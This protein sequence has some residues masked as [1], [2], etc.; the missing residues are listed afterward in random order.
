L[1]NGIH[2]TRLYLLLQLIEQ[3]VANG[4]IQMVATSHSPQL[5]GFLGEK[6]KGSAALVYRL[7]DEPD[8]RIARIVEIAEAERVL[9]EQDLARLF[10]SGWLEDAV[11]FTQPVSG[12]GAGVAVGGKS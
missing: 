8:A 1:E 11:A 10:A 3:H 9:K 6:A 7:K 2:P 4:E 5:L 12:N